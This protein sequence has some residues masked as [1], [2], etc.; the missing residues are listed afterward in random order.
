ME[1]ARSNPPRETLCGVVL[2][3]L[4]LLRHYAMSIS[5]DTAVVVSIAA[6]L[7]GRLA[8]EHI[9]V[10]ANTMSLVRR[11]IWLRLVRVGLGRRPC[12][13]VT[14]DLNVIICKLP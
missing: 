2:F 14:S 11:D 10:R 13:V 12:Q 5:S 3:M 1:I 7:A 8:H 6:P 9:S 4:D